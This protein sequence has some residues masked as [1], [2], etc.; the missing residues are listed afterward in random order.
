MFGRSLIAG[1]NGRQI[2][3]TLAK[4]IA[5]AQQLLLRRLT[6]TRFFVLDG[7]PNGNTATGRN[8]HLANLRNVLLVGRPGTGVGNDDVRVEISLEGDIHW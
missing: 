2:C 4:Q 3:G 5:P 7:C 1:R 8:T 6:A